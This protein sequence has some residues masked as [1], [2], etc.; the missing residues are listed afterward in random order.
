[1]RL[2]AIVAVLWLVGMPAMAQKPKIAVSKPAAPAGA[3]LPTQ[4]EVNEF[5]RRM[6]GYDSSLTWKVQ[7]I[8]PA[9]APGVAHVV[10]TIGGQP[11][12][13]HLYVL[14]G[15]KFAVVG[16]PIPFGADPFAPVRQ[17]LNQKANGVQRGPA[18]AVVTLVEFSDLQCP[19]CRGAQPIIDRLVSEVPEAKLIFQPFPLPMHPWAM[20]AATFGECVRRQK[21][22]AF[23]EFVNQVYSDQANIN[24]SNVD[25]KLKSIATAAGVDAEQASTCASTPEVSREVQQS[26]ELGKSVGVNSTPTLFIHG[27]RITGIADIPYEQLKAMVEFEV[28]EAKSKRAQ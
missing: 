19:F 7:A 1:M 15:K 17:T 21:P 10:A 2:F 3:A 4:A 28:A 23:W 26:I 22:A 13:I 25:T 24:E 6:F 16:D 8:V 20:K 5:L 27:R 11:R 12:A 18:G 14:P 9:E